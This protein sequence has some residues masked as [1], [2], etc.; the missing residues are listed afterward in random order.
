M[1][2]SVYSNLYFEYVLLWLYFWNYF[3]GFI[4][5]AWIFRMSVTVATHNLSA[6]I[7]V[8]VFVF[9]Y[10]NFEATIFAFH[11]NINRLGKCDRICFVKLID[12]LDGD[13]R[14]VY[15]YVRVSEW[16]SVFNKIDI[17]CVHAYFNFAKRNTIVPL[18]CVCV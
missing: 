17:V 18:L 3:R 2:F 13:V 4:V 1:V 8:Y 16:V 14:H 15:M 6:H 12:L 5:F 11:F 9:I 10:H 7:S